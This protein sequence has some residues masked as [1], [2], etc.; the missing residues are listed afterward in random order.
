MD[1][2]TPGSDAIGRRVF[3]WTAAAAIAFA[4]AAYILTS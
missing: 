2:S 3:L 1:N 4:V